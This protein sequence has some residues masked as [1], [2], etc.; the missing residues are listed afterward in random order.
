MRA[1]REDIIQAVLDNKII[2]IA[3]GLEKEQLYKTVEA[4]QKGGIRMVEVTFDQ[5]GKISDTETAV[6]IRMLCEKFGDT[7]Y[8]GAGTVMSE[9]QV[10]LACEAGAQ[11]IISPDCYEP[12]I[13]KTRELGLVSMP[14]CLTPTEAAMA[15][16]WGADFVKLF[17]NS[18]FK[19]SY[20]KAL[21]A[22]LSHI[23]FLSVGGVNENNLRDFIDAGACGVGLTGIVNKKLIAEGKYDEI[24][25]LAELY[26]S[27]I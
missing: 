20:L 23:K 26:V 14:G 5:S 18:E 25:K 2:V 17:P 6:N 12:V 4:M 8:V 7:M 10:E 19:L 27:K 13:K 15:H 24:T 11:F 21:M 16:R 22:P 1:T 3:R 9:S